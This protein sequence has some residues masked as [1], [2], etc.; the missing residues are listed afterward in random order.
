MN[1]ANPIVFIIEGQ[2]NHHDVQT[3]SQVFFQ[4]TGFEIVNSV[5]QKGLCL[6][7]SINEQNTEVQAVLY[8]ESKIFSKYKQ[9]IKNKEK[10]D[11]R[12]AVKFVVYVVLRLYTK[13][14]PPWG[15]LTGIRP[16]KLASDMLNNGLSKEKA[17]KR[18]IKFYLVDKNRSKLCV[19]VALA[20][21]EA[22]EKAGNAC[23]TVSIYINI[24]F[25]PSICNYCSFASCLAPKFTKHM[26]AYIDALAKEIKYINEVC[27][28]KY[29]ENIYIGGG[30]PT[31]LDDDNFRQMLFL[32]AEHFNVE[33][34]LEYTVE[35]GR[36]DT[37]DEKKLNAMRG[38]GVNRISINP[39]TLHDA[40][41]TKIGR[42][43][44][45]ADFY[46]AYE[47]ARKIGFN[48]INIDL[49]LGLQDETIQNVSH[50]LEGITAL[51]PDSVTIHTL[52]VKRASALH[53][54]LENNSYI[55]DIKN[56]EKMLD[57]ANSSMSKA[58]LFPYYLYRQKNSTG[59]FE[60]VGYAKKG[61]AGMYNI[62]MMEE[63]HSVYAAGAGS[64]TKLVNSETGSIERVFNIQNPLDYIKRVDEMIERKAANMEKGRADKH[65]QH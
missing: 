7:V 21:K 65:E 35:A 54:N 62:R 26:H 27:K 37:I 3:M 36:P 8:D 10:Q 63:H 9:K 56:I 4:N 25:C 32:V 45:A 22:V 49:I 58:N 24:P 14:C 41:L 51:N 11:A 5:P 18:L 1:T 40:T 48:H 47:A 59:N 19:D 46:K 42:Q 61:K 20:Q 57:I 28:G 43:H 44:S 31:S 12:R 2:V 52:S 33:N 6:R 34:A 39:Q 55:T 13:Y 60:N 16:A 50:T 15:L 38:Y 30:T 53:Q 64:V 17:E 29:I 23:N